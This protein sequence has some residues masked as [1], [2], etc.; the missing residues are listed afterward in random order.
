MGYVAIVTFS[1]LAAPE[2]VKMTIYDAS[3]NEWVSD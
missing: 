3:N 2:L 1:A